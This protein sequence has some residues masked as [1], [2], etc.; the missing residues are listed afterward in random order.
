MPLYDLIY[1]YP[2]YRNLLTEN[3]ED[4]AVHFVRYLLRTLELEG[5]P[6]TRATLPGRIEHEAGIVKGDA[7]VVKLR[8]FSPEGA[9][10]YSTQAGE[11]GRVN[12]MRYFQ[13]IVARGR[14]YSQLVKKNRM[15]AEGVL[16]TRD[17][18]ETY[19]PVMTRNGFG[20][21]MEIYY[22]VT[23]SRQE[24]ERLNRN[25]S[26]VL[27]ALC[28]GML[29]LIL[30]T[31]RKAQL[32]FKKQLSAEKELQ[33]AK[34]DLEVK[35]QERT[36]QLQQ[37]NQQLKDEISERAL[38]QMALKSALADSQAARERT[39]GILQSMND[40][41]LVVDS[42]LKIALVNPVVKELLGT[43]C[44]SLVGSGLHEAFGQHEAADKIRQVFDDRDSA[45]EFDLRVGSKI[46]RGRLSPVCNDQQR[47]T[48]T[49]LLLQDV[50]QARELDQLKSDFLAMAAHELHTPITTIMGYS[51]L[52][53]PAQ[54]KHFSPEQKQ[55]FL[56]IIHQKAEALANIVDDLLDVSRMEAGQDL[57]LQMESFG[58]K[59]ELEGQLEP[60]LRNHPGH[61][62]VTDA[63]APELRLS[64]DLPRFR[65]L[66][67]NLLSNAIKYS[68]DGG[69]V[70]IAVEQQPG[71]VTLSVSDTGIG[72]TRE[73]ADKAFERF[74]RADSS[75]TAVSG[76][77][78]GLC[79]VKNIIE[80]HGGR[81]WIAS[82]AAV[83]TT[84]HCFFPSSETADA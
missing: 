53:V 3:T 32:Y 49:I 6:L 80:A 5:Q 36:N 72:M 83:G 29:G 20:G 28:I 38:T 56:A 11:I 44:R 2:A 7:K 21:A 14:L 60:Y 31:L 33:T 35:V 57:S 74:Y 67:Q 1:T 70:C 69:R 8:V 77:G 55:D 9:I 27:I 64:A 52:L 65:Q 48:A 81:C 75:D 25:S 45:P 76:T 71:G 24:I 50:T 17:V 79:I 58:L 23:Q 15:S 26:R 66:L 40:G 41:L 73:Q 61:S 51:E 34:D 18:I 59:A 54:S 43:G 42:E 10:L 46:Y 82:Q 13:Q 30:L 37:S 84:I 4:E 47:E 68:P 12:A 63:V 78:L 22:D 19:V 16:V 62:F 39:D